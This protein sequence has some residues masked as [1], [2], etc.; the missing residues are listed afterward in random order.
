MTINTSLLEKIAKQDRT[1]AERILATIGQSLLPNPEGQQ[2]S[3]TADEVAVLAELRAKASRAAAPRTVFSIIEDE[4]SRLS[5]P[6]PSAAKF[7][8]GAKGALPNRSYEVLFPDNF[9]E[10]EAL[11]VRRNH[12]LDAIHSP[13]AFEHLRTIRDTADELPPISVF[14]KAHIG[15]DPFTLI[16]HTTREGDKQRVTAAWRAYHSDVVFQPNASP[17]Q[18]LKSFVEV[19]G[20]RFFVGDEL[21]GGRREELFVLHFSIEVDPTVKNT[22]STVMM[23]LKEI[24]V[25]HS[26]RYRFA[27]DQAVVEIALAYSIVRERYTADIQRHL[28]QRMRR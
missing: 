3:L 27:Q 8:L 5:V 16:V 24:N 25:S 21:F 6:N 13:D 14:V 4:L 17:I 23:P 7:R 19:Y 15:Q 28:G 1:A 2:T 12:V 9:G 11:G 20:R 26:R 10:F 22:V 18:M